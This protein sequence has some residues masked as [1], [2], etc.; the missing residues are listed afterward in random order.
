M[1]IRTHILAWTLLFVALFAW[2]GVG[3]LAWEVN[4][5]SVE[6]EANIIAQKNASDAVSAATWIY[7]I[8]A[9]TQTERTQLDGFIAVDPVA[10]VKSLT[11][12][13]KSIGVVVAIT[14]AGPEEETVGA[15]NSAPH[16]FGFIT[17]SQGTFPSLMHAVD[18][19]EALPAPSSIQQLELVR[20]VPLNSV[21]STSTKTTN[22]QWHMST[23]MR[24]LTSSLL[25][26]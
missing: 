12:A 2:I 3:Y 9:D 4:N 20:V 24:V 5:M 16:A 7:T 6:R 17:D 21:A 23:H 19:F 14:S 1:Y 11:T 8:A 13:A 10:V 22:E 15:S 26:S 25:S 18:L